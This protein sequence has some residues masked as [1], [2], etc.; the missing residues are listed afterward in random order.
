[1]VK[2]SA[3]LTDRLTLTGAYLN[4]T[5]DEPGALGVVSDEFGDEFDVFLNW[6]VNDN[7]SLSAAVAMLVPGDAATQFTG[8]TR[9][10]SHFMLYAS[11]SY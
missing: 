10:W 2:G 4:I 9:T 5:L 7:L 6:G 3:S 8:G 11:F 1:M